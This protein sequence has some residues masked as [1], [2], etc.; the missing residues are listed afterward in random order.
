MLPPSYIGPHCTYLLP[1]YLSYL[2]SF[3]GTQPHHH[4]DCLLTLPT[5]FPMP[6]TYLHV[7]KIYTP[8]IQLFTITCIT[9]VYSHASDLTVFCVVRKSSGGVRDL[10][11]YFR[12]H[13]W[14]FQNITLC[15]VDSFICECTQKTGST[16]KVIIK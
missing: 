4:H 3:S 16:L 12:H 13:K 1:A 6:P 14:I 10:S 11:A 7:H 8:Y 9:L 2:L 15:V 5:L